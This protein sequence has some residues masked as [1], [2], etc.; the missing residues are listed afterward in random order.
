MSSL[1]NTAHVPDYN[2]AICILID[3]LGK[4]NFEKIAFKSIYQTI[5]VLGLRHMQLDIF[6]FH[7]AVS[8]FLY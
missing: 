7:L 5:T 4:R 1:I 3:V 8:Q 2:Y 6:L